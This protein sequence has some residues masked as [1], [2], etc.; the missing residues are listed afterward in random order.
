MHHLS[1]KDAYH[2]ELTN[3]S[4]KRC[5]HFGER[6]HELRVVPVQY[7]KHAISSCGLR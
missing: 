7:S 1:K 3:H 6:R 5:Q 2:K 4:D